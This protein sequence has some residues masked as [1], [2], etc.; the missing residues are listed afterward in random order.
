MKKRNYLIQKITFVLLPIL[1]LGQS[2]NNF[3]VEPDSTY[4]GTESSEN[5]DSTQSNTTLTITSDAIEGVGA[6]QI[7]YSVHNSEGWGGYT[8]LYHY[9]NPVLDNTGSSIEGSWMLAPE[10]GAMK[11]GPTAGSG[12]YWTSSEEDVANRACIF[13]DHYV[14]NADGSFQNVLGDQ[15][16]IEGWQ[17]GDQ[18]GDGN[19]DWQDELCDA[20]MAPHDGSN[21]A[22]WEYDAASGEVTLTGL[23]AYL[24]LPKAVN[25]GELT[26]PDIAV[27]ESRTYS[28]T[29]DGGEMTVV[30]ECGTGLFWT[31]KLV[32][33]TQDVLLTGS[34]MLAPEAGAMKV[35]PTAG[36]GSYW[37][38]SD[39]DVTNRACI[40][41]DHYVFNADG[42][43]QNVLGDQTWIEGWQGGDQNGDGNL[44]WQD[45]LCD[46]PM[47]PHDG[48]NAATWEYDAASGEV[49]LTG[50]GAYL[51]LPKA[52][53]AGELTNP[54]IAVPESR[55]YSVT[56]DGGEMTVVIE[57][58]TGLFWTFKLVPA[59]TAMVLNN[60]WMNDD[61]ST[62]VEM[63]PRD[64]GPWDWSGYDSIS[65][66][67][68]NTVM[69]SKQG[70]VH[71]RLNISDYAEVG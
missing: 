28:V 36:S 1:V 53:N 15:T 46:A 30:I 20:P 3:D 10:A 9:A 38:N 69:A 16:W 34:W 56:Q 22:T 63:R 64:G 8:K 23:G 65:F 4:W 41:D 57:C 11:V 68:N 55:T 7:D 49:T 61:F 14:F 33:Q 40:F 43:F 19:L 29:Q 24:G 52:V 60:N 6:L 58:G 2:I 47:A 54:D 51:G 45:E 37:S 66:S 31:F 21:A 50:L 12:E 42:S 5:S 17:G 13:D 39:Q 32:S 62:L 44:D 71:L 27:P 59:Q 70:R 35:G 48:S 26:N 67:Y 18:N 25:A